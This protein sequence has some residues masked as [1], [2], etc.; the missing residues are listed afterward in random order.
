MYRQV[1]N[2]K[3]NSTCL[4]AIVHSLLFSNGNL[5]IWQQVH[6]LDGMKPTHVFYVGSLLHWFSEPYIHFHLKSLGDLNV[7]MTD[8]R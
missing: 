4:P 6:I 2:Y 8:A 5:S 3:L 1:G 7:D